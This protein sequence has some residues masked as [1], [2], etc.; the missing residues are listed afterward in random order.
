MVQEFPGKEWTRTRSSNRRNASRA[1]NKQAL[2][3]AIQ[4]SKVL[5]FNQLVLEQSTE[6]ERVKEDRPI[7][8]EES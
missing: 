6:S 5:F 8:R 1:G 7:S 2:L 3:I 4:Y